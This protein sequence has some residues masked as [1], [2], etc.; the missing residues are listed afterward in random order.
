M[1]LQKKAN[2]GKERKYDT[3]IAGLLGGYIVFGERNAINEQVRPPGHIAPFYFLIIALPR[4]HF[5]RLSRSYS[6]SAPV[7]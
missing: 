3:F 6:M 7:S 5:L 4:L 1:L 2:G